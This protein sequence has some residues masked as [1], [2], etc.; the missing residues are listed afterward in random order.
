MLQPLLVSKPDPSSLILPSAYSEADNF[1]QF[2]LHAR[3]IAA[4]KIAPLRAFCTV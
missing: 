2:S 4:S 3:A 1:I